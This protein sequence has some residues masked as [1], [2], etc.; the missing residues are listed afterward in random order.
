MPP[1]FTLPAKL[2]LLHWAYAVNWGN[3]AVCVVVVVV[4]VLARQQEVDSGNEQAYDVGAGVS[5]VM[6]VVLVQCVSEL[7]HYGPSYY[8]WAGSFPWELS[9][10]A[11]FTYVVVDVVVNSG[12]TVP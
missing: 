5:V 6:L 3:S 11:C 9:L 2:L 10:R 12:G 8:A 7:L 4:V 1:P